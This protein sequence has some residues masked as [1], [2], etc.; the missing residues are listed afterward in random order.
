MYPKST[1][2]SFA[3]LYWESSGLASW[4]GIVL[5]FGMRGIVVLGAL[6]V[7]CALAVVHSMDG[8]DEHR[9]SPRK[10]AGKEVAKGG[11]SVQAIRGLV[12]ASLTMPMSRRAAQVRNRD[13]HVG[14]HA[15]RMPAVDDRVWAEFSSSRRVNHI[16]LPATIAAL[17]Y[18]DNGNV[19]SVY[20]TLWHR[21]ADFTHRN[22][23]Q[24]YF[25]NEVAPG[26]FPG[27]DEEYSESYDDI[28]EERN[29][30]TSVGGIGLSQQLP[31]PVPVLMHMPVHVPVQAGS[32]DTMEQVRAELLESQ[33]LL[34]ET[35][36]SLATALAI[37]E[38]WR[39]MVQ[40]H[41]AHPTVLGI[42]SQ[43]S[44]TYRRFVS[45]EGASRAQGS[46]SGAQA[47]APRTA[48]P[49]PLVE[50]SAA[51]SAQARAP[52]TAQPP[53]P[54]EAFARTTR[55]APVHGTPDSSQPSSP[56]QCSAAADASSRAVTFAPAAERRRTGR[57]RTPI[58]FYAP[59]EEMDEKPADWWPGPGP[60]PPGW[61]A[62]GGA[63]S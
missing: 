35:R 19:S 52:R 53:P 47:R 20:V 3:L 4:H 22:P 39:L 5:V 59:A 26:D 46:S 50:A 13:A 34:A 49:P 27:I 23:D 43:N 9:K 36:A 1:C 15:S 29:Y 31:M 7:A 14:M 38:E 10:S 24:V 56:V 8:G 51:A 54:V 45:T 12:I 61:P 58:N 55:A 18:D 63:A 41:E 2:S 42:F 60:C 16:M 62:P 48:Q 40:Q 30:Q 17:N 57:V 44:S 6:L 11:M 28:V 33:R 25:R 37:G 21:Y 32:G